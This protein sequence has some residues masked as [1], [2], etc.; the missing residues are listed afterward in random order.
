[1]E[2]IGGLSPVVHESRRP[3]GDET[4]VDVGAGVGYLGGLGHLFE[5][6]GTQV[7]LVQTYRY[8]KWPQSF[9]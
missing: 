6:I 4:L 9:R 3:Q 2:L 7:A 8:K 1:V 5:M